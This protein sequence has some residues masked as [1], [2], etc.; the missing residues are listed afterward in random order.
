M[1]AMPPNLLNRSALSQHLRSM[2]QRL[3]ASFCRIPEVRVA[4]LIDDLG[5]EHIRVSGKNETDVSLKNL[6]DVLRVARVA[7]EVLG[8]GQ[9]HQCWF[10]APNG[11]IMV[12]P[13]PDGMS[14]AIVTG[15]EPNLGRL[16]HEIQLRE[17]AI[18]QLL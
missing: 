14:L 18:L 11:C 15:A 7:A 12:R 8:I 5:S 3:L 9:A 2:L 10:E 1:G 17:N 16:S 13:L 4:T 6:S